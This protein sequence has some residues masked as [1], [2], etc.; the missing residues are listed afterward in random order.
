MQI[1]KRHHHADARTI[2]VRIVALVCALLLVGTVLLAAF[3]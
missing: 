2:F 3:S 1:Q